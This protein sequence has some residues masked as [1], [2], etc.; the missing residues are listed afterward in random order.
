VVPAHP[1]AK[2][3]IPIAP[4][5]SKELLPDATLASIA[6]PMMVLVGTNDKT[7]PVDPNVTR[8]WTLSKNAPAYRVELVAGQ[9]QTFTDICAY[10]TFVPKLANVPEVITKTIDSFAAEG[11]AQSDIDPK[12]AAEL[13]NSYVVRFLDQVLRDGPVLSSTANPKDVIFAAR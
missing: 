10:Q 11:C 4:A 3:I 6:V 12:R 8:L 7:T 2:A 13:A 1:T 9:H 5:A